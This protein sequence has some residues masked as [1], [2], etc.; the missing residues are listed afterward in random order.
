MLKTSSTFYLALTRARVCSVKMYLVLCVFVTFKGSTLKSSWNKTMST[1]SEIYFVSQS[2][3]AVAIRTS[4]AVFS[5]SRSH[6]RLNRFSRMHLVG[7]LLQRTSLVLLLITLVGDVE[8]NPGFRRLV[9]IKSTRGLKIAHLNVRSLRNKVDLLRLEQFDN[10][11]IDVLTLSETWLDS[12]IQDSEI[13]LPGFTLVRRD[14]EGS[15]SGGGVAIYVRD[16]LPFRVRNDIDNGE[17]ECLWIELIIERI[18]LEA[19]NVDFLLKHAYGCNLNMQILHNFMR[20]LD[21]SQIITEPTRITE[22]SKSLIDVILV[23]NQH[24]IVDSGVVP[25][26]ISDHSLIYC[27][28]KAGVPKAT[29]RT[30]EYR[31]YRRF[32]ENAFIQDLNNVPWHIVDDESNVNDAVLTWNRLF[33]EVADSHAPLKKRRVKGATAPWMNN[34]IAEAMRD[35]NYHLRK[36][37]KTNSTYHWRMYRKLRNFVNREIKSSKSNHYCNLI[38][39]GKGDSSMIWKAVNEASSRNVSSSIP[40]CIISSGVQ[41]TDPKSIATTLNDYFASVGRLLAEKFSQSH[42]YVNPVKLKVTEPATDSFE[43][44]PVSHSFVL[45]QICALKRNKA[46]GLDRISARL[47]KCASR[48]ITPSITK[49]LNLSIATN[50]FP[51]IW[52]CA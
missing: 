51:N 26:S 12:N 8:V 38:E 46:I 40:Q 29:P 2:N 3:A 23:N 17:N 48:T 33:T 28:V 11:A 43:L 7:E 6:S 5:T 41:Y 19:M 44:R 47:L 27:I 13:C 37:Q 15:K 9:D 4:S 52:K 30:I 50:E 36:A 22:Q 34:K 16:G 20:S 18:I 21:L 42:N 14:R 35:R 25:L 45:K 1:D 32:D 31:S 10:I 24:R 39:E 49:L